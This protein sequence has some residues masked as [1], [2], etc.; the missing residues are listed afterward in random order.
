M[1]RALRGR[2]RRAGDVL[3]QRAACARDPGP[4]TD[5]DLSNEALPFAAARL[6]DV[7]LGRAWVLRRSFVGELG[8]EIYPT[9]DLARHV[10]EELL[11][12]GAPHGL[13]HGGFLAMNHGRLEKAFAHYGHDI[14][15][16]DNPLEAGLGFAVAFDKPGGFVGREALLR[17]R[18][19]GALASRL[20]ERCA[21]TARRSRPAPTCCATSRSGAAASWSGTSPRAPGAFAS[22][23]RSA[24]AG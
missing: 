1:A 2:D 19:A 11:R 24:W 16:D 23:P 10:Y 14:A 4:L 15:E 21:S 3:A 13:R 18:E 17:L 8:Y 7:G 22:A 5:A 9:T 20:V 12:A 6:V